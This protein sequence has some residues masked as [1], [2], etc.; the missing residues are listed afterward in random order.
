MNGFFYLTEFSN[1]KRVHVLKKAAG[2]TT[3]PV[4]RREK[5]TANATTNVKTRFTV[6]FCNNK[7]YA[8]QGEDKEKNE[9]QQSEGN[10]L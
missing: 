2:R 9:Q 8:K 1:F 5:A 7:N 3:A 10:I 6:H 4:K